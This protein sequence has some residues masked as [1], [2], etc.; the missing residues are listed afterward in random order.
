MIGRIADLKFKNTETND[1]LLA[2][3][4][5]FVLDDIIPP[6]LKVPRN[7]TNIVIVEESESDDDY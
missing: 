6:M 2:K 1:E 4:I 3:R 5:E 7:E